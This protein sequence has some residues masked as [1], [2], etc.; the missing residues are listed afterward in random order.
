MVHWIYI[1]ECEDRYLYIGETTRLYRR[2]TEHQRGGG[3]MNTS[4]HYPEKLVGLY[5]V[6]DNYSFLQYRNCILK[7]DFNKYIINNWGDDD[8][9]NLEIEN[10]FTELYMYLRNKKDENFMYDD[11]QWNKVRGG[12]YTK[13]VWKNPTLLMNDKDTIDRPNCNC[14][15]PAE[16]K[17]SKDKKIIYFVCSLKNVWENFYKG[18]IIDEPCDFYKVY[19]D[20]A[21]P[22]KIYE[23]AE[24]KIKEKWGSNVPITDSIYPDPCIKCK[25]TDYIPFYSWYNNRRICRECILNNYSELSKEYLTSKTCFIE[26]EDSD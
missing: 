13:D 4:R 1:L 22:R 16:V 7:N 18:L 3:A 20:D 21:I 8:S 11:G 2:F 23:I 9:A 5:K 25:T 19:S 12:K 10:H 15:V 26:D 17:L 6:S 24:A 14:L